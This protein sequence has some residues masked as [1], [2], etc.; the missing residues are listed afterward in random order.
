MALQQL[1]LVEGAPAPSAQDWFL[2]QLLVGGG[3]EY[4]DDCYAA[5]VA[6]E[7]W[8]GVLNL[9]QRVRH[10]RLASMKLTEAIW[11]DL[12]TW[13]ALQTLQL[14]NGQMLRF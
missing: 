7:L 14:P 3:D 6:A 5:E 9:R 2:G 8:W 11:R 13:P 4:E 10:V 1:N 12:Q